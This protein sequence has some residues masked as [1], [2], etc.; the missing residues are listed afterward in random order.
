[1]AKQFGLGQSTI[2]QIRQVF[3]AH[4]EV[5]SVVLYGSRAKGNYKVG[6]DIDFSMKGE[7]L[8]FSLLSSIADELDELPLPYQFDLSIFDNIS[9]PDLVAHIE[10]VG[11]LFYKRGA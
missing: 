11:V 8:E 4:S 2:D 7:G 10:R 3:S 1:M 6:S 5:E 9:S